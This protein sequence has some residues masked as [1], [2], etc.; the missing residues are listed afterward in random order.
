MPEF[1]HLHVHSEY[2]LLDGAIRIT[3]LCQKAKD[4]GMPAVALTDHGN[5]HGAVTFYMQAQKMGL[6]PIIGCEIYVAPGDMTDR[7]PETS[8][9]NHLVLLAKNLEGYRNLIAIVSEA[10]L[11][12]FYYKPRADK[13]L[14]RRHSAGLVALSACL[15]GEVP[16]ALLSQGMDAGE[17][18]ARE[19]AEIFPGEFYLEL[20]DN[21]IEK[22]NRLNAMLIDLA[23]RTGLP[24][25][26]TNDCHY[27][28]K[29]DDEAHD[30]L[31]CIQTGKTVDT[32]GRMR[33]DTDQ[34]YF[35]T[36]EEMEK[37]FAAVPE[38][39]A[40][41]QRI[42]ERCNVE[43]ELGKHSFPVYELPEGVS[44]DQE[45]ERMAREGLEARIQAAP[46][47][48]DAEAYRKRLEYEIGVIKEMGFPAYF[49]IV[50][51]FINWAK[52]HRIPVGPGRGSAAGSIVAWALRIT[53]LDPIPYQLLFERFLNVER[54]SMPDI[55]V[56]FCERRRLE[57]VRYVAGKYGEDHV[58][59][60]TTFGTMKAKAV[61]RDVARALGMT[62]AEGDRIAKLVPEE[63]KMT[64]A[65]ALEREPELKRLYDSD[66]QVKK[67]LDVAKRLEG[68]AR[69]ASTHAAGVVISAE[70]MTHYLPLYA[71]KK[72]EV[73]TQYDGKRVELVGLIK[74]D[75]LGL[76]TMTVIEDCLDIIREQGKQPP[77]LDNLPLT[78]PAVY[79]LFS[80][81]DTDGIFQVESSGMRKYLR[82]LKPNRF[83]DII[84]MLALYR[85]GPLGSG[86]VDE[87]IKRKHGEIP[88]TYPHASLEETLSPTYGVIVYQEQV[89]ATAMVI[90]NYSLGE[91]DLL[92][93][94]MG[95]KKAEEMAKQRKRFLE[96][97]AENKIPETTANEI[98]DLMEKFAEYGFNKSHSA[99]YALISYYTAY[100]KVHHKVE[101]MAALISSELANADKV[102]AYINSC[103]EMDIE[104]AG[105]DVNKSRR[106]FSVDNGIIRFGLAGVKNV[107][108]EAV[109]DIV[110][111]REE[112]GP[113]TGL[114][115]FCRRVNLRK[116]TKRVTES[117]IKAGAMD[118]FG[119]SRAG[120][121][122]GLEKAYGVGQREAKERA[123]GMISMLDMLGGMGGPGGGKGDAK[124]QAASNPAACV[125][126]EEF[127]Q[128]EFPDAEKQ[129]L[130]KEVLGF[131]LSSHPLLAYRMDLPRLGVRTLEHCRSLPDGAEARVAVIVPAVKEYIN[132]KGEKMAFCQ[133]EDLSGT[134]ELTVF[135]SLYP[136]AKA[137]IATEE[138][139]L[140]VAKADRRDGAG[141]DDQKAK[142]VAERFELLRDV[143]SR[144]S[145]PVPLP[146]AEE[147]LD[148]AGIGRLKG[149][150]AAHPGE[151][152]VRLRV[153]RGDAVYLV[154]LG[155]QW[156][157][158]PN[159]DFWND[160]RQ[161][162]AESRGGAGDGGEEAP[163]GPDAGAEPRDD[164][165]LDEYAAESAFDTDPDGIAEAIGPD[166][167]MPDYEESA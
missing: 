107:G 78:D 101:F 147:D 52:D 92:R 100:L 137:L 85:P 15:G 68:L 79:A 122:A 105:P 47:A 112:H 127:N 95:K 139:I 10:H 104:V 72:G 27:L 45:F 48:I 153:A 166:A 140:V 7:R 102:Y 155:S 74:F 145:T 21:G 132:K 136:E 42:A 106:R 151:V 148:E 129:R 103:R 126:I 53:N 93:R 75:F 161:Y 150:I 131:Y 34:L 99:A 46:Y 163:F 94:A 65:K 30:V 89:M 77:D 24:L 9:A 66:T 28:N 50:Q 61:V 111:E 18:V 20:Q 43:I 90:A 117:L 80:R 33:M 120:L 16:H 35:K 31:I 130:E 121:I 123:S 167:P 91:G 135:P 143:Q 13:A 41:T 1:V 3:D 22:Q 32:P 23:G 67:L 58:A 154:E 146:V 62:F 12:G 83:E 157:I 14:L 86:M 159:G 96:G 156:R 113:Y 44:I 57:V 87:F 2:S 125:S 109:N 124:D 40:N 141:G 63:M 97:A 160:F 108:D 60:I 81:G 82:M 59:Q 76:R 70:P 164:A 56:D 5:M 11:K 39:I 152:P 8:G 162:Q 54:V 37:A 84:A 51:D 64:I 149:L 73:V 142:L 4:L 110:R 26:A 144:N 128:E 29:G 88:V 98:F 6:K 55:D 38:A 71:G 19:Y 36:P 17:A 25:V 133:I 165:D 114:V 138:P 116:V 158:W 69:H 119:C 134:G 118:G 115:D 49:L